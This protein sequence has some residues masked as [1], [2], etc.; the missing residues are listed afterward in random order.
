MQASPKVGTIGELTFV[1]EQNHAIDFADGDMPAVLSTPWL[2][3]FLEHAARKAMLPLLEKGESTVGVHVDVQHLAATPLGQRVNC[4]ARVI[5]CE[6]TL[7]SFQLEAH[8]EHER[9]ARG[10]HKLRVIQV[11]RFADRVRGKLRS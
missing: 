11:A 1:V 10:V 4:R 5:H 9:I 2:I 8:D 6:G 7:V 3:W